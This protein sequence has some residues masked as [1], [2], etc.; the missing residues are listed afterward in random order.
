MKRLFFGIICLFLTASSVYGKQPGEPLQITIKT[1]A[2]VLLNESN[3][4]RPS[5]GLSAK[6]VFSYDDSQSYAKVIRPK[7][8][9]RNDSKEPIKFLMSVYFAG[10][11]SIKN[12]N[13]SK[14]QNGGV[15]RSGGQGVEVVIIKPNEVV[16][17]DTYDYGYGVSS[18]HNI[19]V[20]NTISVQA[21]L[22][23]GKYIIDYTL[24]LNEETIEKALSLFDW[25]KEK[26]S[27]FW[28]GRISINNT[29][30]VLK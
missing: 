24:V 29:E 10:K 27:A 25:I 14:V 28:K 26:P 3:W 2:E 7:L 20:F 23:P 9:L 1:D 6:L 8:L 13:G 4:S 30:V 5:N 15:T 17:F 21:D 19:Y 22:K 18:N 12:S 11:F 16:K